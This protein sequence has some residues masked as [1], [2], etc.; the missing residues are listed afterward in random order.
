MVQDLYFKCQV[1]DSNC[2]WLKHE[3]CITSFNEIIILSTYSVLV[4][5]NTENDFKNRCWTCHLNAVSKLSSFALQKRFVV[6]GPLENVNGT[7]HV[8]KE[9]VCSS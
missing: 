8:W 7:N 3:D 1:Y 9:T 5:M 2:V 6:T 4:S